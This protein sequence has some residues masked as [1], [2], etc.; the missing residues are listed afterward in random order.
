MFYPVALEQTPRL[1]ILPTKQEDWKG[2]LERFS[3]F[4]PASH[5]FL[6]L[7]SFGS[8]EEMGHRSPLTGTRSTPTLLLVSLHLSFFLRIGA[9]FSRESTCFLGVLLIASL[10]PTTMVNIVFFF[11]FAT[12]FRAALLMCDT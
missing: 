6:L 4:Q 7:R 8:G 10:A 1:Y 9:P 3:P 2:L 5:T 12:D 11:G